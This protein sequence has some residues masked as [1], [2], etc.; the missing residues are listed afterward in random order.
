M[1]YKELVQKLNEKYK[2]N[3]FYV[4]S[5]EDYNVS[6]DYCYINV[7]INVGS[8]CNIKVQPETLVLSDFTCFN[9]V[10]GEN[11]AMLKKSFD[12]AKTY[13]QQKR[14]IEKLKNEQEKLK[15]ELSSK[16]GIESF[17]KDIILKA[18]TG[19]RQ[20]KI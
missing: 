19:A 18:I 15:Q 1:T 11:L 14:D 2:T 12:L 3:I 20:W 17:S 7:D 9:E 6:G 13:D 16:K 10:N 5:A 4:N 8:T